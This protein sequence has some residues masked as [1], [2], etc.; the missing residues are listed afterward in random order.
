MKRLLVL[1]LLALPLRAQN[2]ILLTW[3][4][5]DSSGITRQVVCRSTVSGAENCGAA[6]ATLSAT[7]TSYNDVVGITG[8]PY[9]YVMEACILSLC[10]VKSNE[11]TAIGTFP[12]AP[13]PETNLQAVPH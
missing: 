4:L 3:T 9:F 5:S 6:Y 2:G 13:N 12:V 8:Q 11:A 1:L 10:S 7:A